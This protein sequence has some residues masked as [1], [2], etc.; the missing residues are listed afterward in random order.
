MCRRC[1][2]CEGMLHHWDENEHCGNDLKEIIIAEDC[3]HDRAMLLAQ[4]DLAC[5]HCDA[6]ANRC[7]SCDGNGVD[8][9]EEPCMWC[10]GNE[11]HMVCEESVDA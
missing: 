5:K 7:S 11:I 10:E 9:D 3:S 6:L 1:T 8:D 4:A 2:E